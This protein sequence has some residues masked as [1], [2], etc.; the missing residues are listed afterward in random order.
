MKE[1]FEEHI[2]EGWSIKVAKSVE[3]VEELRG[4]WQEWQWH[5]NADIDFY[6]TI[7]NARPEI[8]RPHVILLLSNDQPV[9]MMIGRI[10]EKKFEFKIGYKSFYGPKVRLLTI[11][12]GGILGDHSLRRCS[13]F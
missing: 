13:F 10:E 4:T 1:N 9:A 11:I 6:L 3:D 5:P 7:V 8:L 2:P 12:Y